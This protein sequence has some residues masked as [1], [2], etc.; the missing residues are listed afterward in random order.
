MHACP[1]TDGNGASQQCSIGLHH[2][3]SGILG[4]QACHANICVVMAWV[5]SLSASHVYP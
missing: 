5:E 1:N 4:Q 3:C 2:L